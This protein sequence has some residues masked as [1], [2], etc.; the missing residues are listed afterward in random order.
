MTWNQQKG[1]VSNVKDGIENLGLWG[2]L[3]NEQ[4]D[5]KK[6]MASRDFGD[7]WTKNAIWI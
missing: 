6:E 2:M 7:F 5:N 4:L 1:V 3:L